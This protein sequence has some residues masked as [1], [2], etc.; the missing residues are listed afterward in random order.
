MPSP[1]FAAIIREASR[2]HQ[3]GLLRLRRLGQLFGECEQARAYD[4][5]F[6]LR[7]R[8]RAPGR[9]QANLACGKRKAF[10]RLFGGGF[11]KIGQ[12]RIGDPV[13]VVEAVQGL[14]LKMV[15]Q[16]FAHPGN[17]PRFSRVRLRSR[18]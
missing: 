10:V 8:G 18:L 1:W 6:P 4:R 15:A 5:I 16:F 13:R 17:A 11:R 3:L 12:R 14:D 9:E 7:R 2:G